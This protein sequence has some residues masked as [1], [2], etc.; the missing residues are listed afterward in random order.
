MGGAPVQT[1]VV[2]VLSGPN[3]GLAHASAAERVTIGSAAGNDVVLGDRSVSRYHVELSRSAEG[4][5]VRDLRSTNGTRLGPLLLRGSEAIAPA[6]TQLQLG[7]SV[8]RLE[9]GEIALLEIHGHAGLG[10]LRGNSPLMRRLMARTL[11]A[12]RQG[13]VSVLVVGESGTGKELVARAIHDAGARAGGPFVIVDC[14]AIPPSLFAAELFGYERGAFTGADRQRA[15]ALERAR[16]GTLFLDEIGEL[17]AE[18]QATLLGALERRSIR[19]VGGSQEIPIDVRVLSATNRDLRGEVNAGTFRLDLYYRLA[20]VVLETP[21]LSAHP[22]D[23]PSL[24]EHFLAESGHGGVARDVFDE[25]ALDELRRHAWPGNVRELRN[26]I[27]ST[28][29]MGESPLLE[30]THR[31]AA[32]AAGEGATAGDEL[33][34]LPYREARA[35]V[36][37]EFEQ[38][39]LSQLIQRSEGNVRRAAREASM[40]RNHLTD[41]LK[42]HKLK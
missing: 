41:L 1:I 6:G 40:D 22:E 42:R 38:R 10:G 35:R 14:A 39:Y 34:S 30:T 32:A 28:L 5:L 18:M 12:A 24:I 25:R 33:L 15:G 29:A 23:I 31:V 9:D 17:P 11:K 16:G 13:D 19:R 2:R 27:A 3:A 7:A 20:V 37:S 8:L 26:V 36:L 4:I 21:P